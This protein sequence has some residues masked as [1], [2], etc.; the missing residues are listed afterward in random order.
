[1]QGDI[2]RIKLEEALKAKYPEYL[3]IQEV[4]DIC[5]AV[6]RKLSN[7]ERRFRKDER[8]LKY[9]IPHEKIWNENHKAIIGYKWIPEEVEQSEPV[10]EIKPK[11]EQLFMP[12]RVIN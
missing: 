10:I 1:M 5:R 6:G 9:Y 2:L 12:G 11:Q 7:G 8:V 3:S 4:E